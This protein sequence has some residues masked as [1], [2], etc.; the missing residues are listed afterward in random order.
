[1]ARCT[2]NRMESPLAIGLRRC[3]D[4]CEQTLERYLGADV[5]AT[6]EFAG[7]VIAATAALRAVL[8]NESAGAEL[9]GA[10]LDTAARVSR[11]AAATIRN[12]GLD[13]DLLRCAD[14]CE[15]AAFLCE[16]DTAI[17]C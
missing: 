3:N 13:D 16:A 6:Q 8:E 5:D 2:E 1:M 7:A 11:T 14:A 15:R 12:S 10:L 4:V 9:R 17:D